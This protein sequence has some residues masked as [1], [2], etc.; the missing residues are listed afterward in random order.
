LRTTEIV[1]MQQIIYTRIL[2]SII[3][4]VAVMMLFSC[5]NSISKIKEITAQEDTLAA[6]S[7]YD[8]IYE[9]SDS[10][11]VQVK[12]VS[13]L[14]LR[15]GGDDPYSEFPEGF[16][17][18][19][20]DETGKEVSFISA[21]YGITY[22]K[23]KFMRASDNVII[24]NYESHKE[25]YTENL[26]WNQKTKI[27]RSNTFVKMIEPEKVIYGD[28]MWANENFTEREIYNMKGEFDVNEEEDEEI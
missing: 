24:K 3:M 8:M 1:T 18:Y 9:R 5:E 26:I 12:L 21:N 14:M 15:F 19:F 20:Y 17:I 16:I 25:L 11:N 10:G 28:S 22:D 4:V 23:Q 2:K 7:T 6:I 13:K 27:I